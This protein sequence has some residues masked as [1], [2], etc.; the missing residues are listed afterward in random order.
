MMRVESTISGTVSVILPC[1]NVAPY[2]DQCLESLVRQTWES[3]E[4][5]CIND[6]ST[7]GTSAVLH[8]WAARDRRIRVVD[9]ENGGQA[10]AR[11]VGMDMASGEYIAF[12]DPDDYVEHSMYG[13]LME[14]ICTHDADVVAC[15][16]TSFSDENGSVLEELSRSPG[17]GVEKEARSSFFHADSVWMKMDVVTCNKL[18][19]KE[20]LNKCGVRFEPSFRREEDDV[21]W[22]MVLPYAGCLVVVPDRLY[23]YRRKRQGTVSHAW[24]EQGCPYSLDMARLEYVT[25]CWEQIGWLD[26]AVSRGWLAH[27]M[28]RYLLSH[29]TSGEEIFQKLDKQESQA[30]VQRCRKWLHGMETGADPVGLNKWDRA[31]CRLLRTEPVKANPVAEIYNRL[32]SACSGRRG[33]Y[34]RLKSLMSSLS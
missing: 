24:E 4:I 5:I 34:Y 27:I 14:E 25:A 6:G 13:R 28:K 32:M 1:Y 11:N 16:Y 17:F 21:F 23:W 31:F 30:L 18:Y 3:L 20:F 7:D 33:R 22:L 26:T 9:R 2:L 8:S 12:A 19:K 29:V 15:G 10:S